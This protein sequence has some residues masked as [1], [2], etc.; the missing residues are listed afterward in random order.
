MLDRTQYLVSHYKR[1]PEQKD[2]MLKILAQFLQL[3]EMVEKKI[4]PTKEQMIIW[5]VI[6]TETSFN[7]DATEA[8]LK[9]DLCQEAKIFEAQRVLM[10]TLNGS[11]MISIGDATG[12]R[13]FPDKI[14]LAQVGKTEI[15]TMQ[16]AADII[17]KTLL[18]KS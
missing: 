14:T 17:V 8:I 6:M 10:K 18:K 3:A 7:N 1:D 2:S 13:I 4:K 5:D 9:V 16:E 11:A 15:I 12:I